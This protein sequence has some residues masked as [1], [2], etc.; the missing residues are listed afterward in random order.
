VDCKWGEWNEWGSCD[1]CGPTGQRKRTRNII[2]AAKN[3]GVPCKT[4]ASETVGKCNLDCKSTYCNWANWGPYTDCS[5]T[6]GSAQ[7]SRRRY[8][9][10]SD[11][12]APHLVVNITGKGDIAVK[13]S[14]MEGHLQ[15]LKS[16]QLQDVSLAFLGGGIAFVVILSAVRLQS[17]VRSR[18]SSTVHY[19]KMGQCLPDDA[20]TARQMQ[21]VHPRVVSQCVDSCEDGFDLDVPSHSNAALPMLGRRPVLRSSLDFTGDERDVGLE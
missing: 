14:E 13:Y 9:E 18:R 21:S 8:L 2:Q 1:T 20:A 7:K 4:D 5:A 19:S 3:G 17:F 11:S 10:L 16:N 6:C 12:N 15:D